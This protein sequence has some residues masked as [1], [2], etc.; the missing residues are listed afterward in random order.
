M[1]NT[2]YGGI[3]VIACAAFGSSGPVEIR[4]PSPLFVPFAGQ[5]PD[6]NP[7]KPQWTFLSFPRIKEHLPLLLLALVVVIFGV[8]ASA[9]YALHTSDIELGWHFKSKPKNLT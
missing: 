2:H 5:S 7:T 6:T 8:L 3:H 1:H 4:A 9:A